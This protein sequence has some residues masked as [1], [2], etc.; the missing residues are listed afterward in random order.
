MAWFI[1]QSLPVI[2]AAFSLGL[3]VGWLVWGNRKPSPVVSQGDSVIVVERETVV[4]PR[5]SA[6]VAGEAI[7]GEAIA[8]EKE[9]RRLPDGAV[10]LAPEPTIVNGAPMTD[11]DDIVDDDDL[12]RIEGI[13]P[14]MAAAL[15]A[16]GITS[17]QR[18][19]ATDD[20]ARRAAIEA[21][22]LSFAPSLVTWGRQA[23]L[24]ADG[25]ET[26]FAELTERL[27]AG[28]DTGRA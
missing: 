4:A 21:A 1:G 13:G 2:L 12:E 23:Q 25:D 18:L 8:R 17:F 6:P 5:E 15:R 11:P 19:A 14:K 3:L 27:V 10:P 28:R 22:G 16:A 7:A 9:A 24:L 26:A 20:G